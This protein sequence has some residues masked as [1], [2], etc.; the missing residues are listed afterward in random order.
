[1]EGLSTDIAKILYLSHQL[2]VSNIID[3]D[4]KK[5][6]KLRVIQDDQRLL[7]AFSEFV[8]MPNFLK[9]VSD[10]PIG[11]STKER[12][13]KILTENGVIKNTS[14]LLNAQSASRSK[15]GDSS[16]LSNRQKKFGD[17]ASPN[18]EGKINLA[19]EQNKFL[20]L[21]LQINAGQQE[22]FEDLTSPLDSKI[23][24]KK[25][26]KRDQKEDNQDKRF[27]DQKQRPT[28]NINNSRMLNCDVGQSP[29]VLSLNQNRNSKL[30]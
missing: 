26:D 21:N 16:L 27:N 20:Q 13:L 23:I 7:K 24:K 30:R 3:L 15:G 17:R 14:T 22:Y 1:M 19:Q 11:K 6:L 5:N 4:Q 18:G 12:C 9:Q 29:V 2:F 28:L 10:I 8:N 25:Q